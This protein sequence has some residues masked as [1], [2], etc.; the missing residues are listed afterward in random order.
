RCRHKQAVA[1]RPCSDSGAK[2]CK[3]GPRR[4]FA[5]AAAV[6]FI[7]TAST[8]TR[9]RLLRKLCRVA[10]PPKRLFARRRNQSSGDKGRL[11]CFGASPLANDEGVGL[12]LID[13]LPE[14][15]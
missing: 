9:R 11:E 4:V 3:S 10:S 12:I 7:V 1:P 6:D 5:C 15:R 8:A 13:E 14:E 2:C